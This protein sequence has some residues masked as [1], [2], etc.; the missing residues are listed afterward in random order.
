MIR[1]TIGWLGA[2]LAVFLGVPLLVTALAWY[3]RAALVV[4]INLR[5]VGEFGF[6]TVARILLARY[7]AGLPL[8]RVPNGTPEA[9]E[10]GQDHP[11]HPDKRRRFRP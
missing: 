3:A 10:A 7:S 5:D 1:L 9:P 2:V 4:I 8:I 6:W 11:F